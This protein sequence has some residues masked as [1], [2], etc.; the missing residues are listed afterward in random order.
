M[1]NT[2]NRYGPLAGRLLIAFIFIF[3]GYGKL[4]GFDGTVGYIA[5]KDMPLPELA[6]AAA[7]LIELGGGLMLAL[8]WKARWAAGALMVF[9]AMTAVIF[10]NFWSVAPDQVQN[11][12]IHFMKNLSIMGGLL[13]VVVHDSGPLSL[14]RDAAAGRL[15]TA[16]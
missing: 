8:G 6:A 16:R 9:T 3:A 2:L 7:I 14:R 1:E 13:Y 4:T 12:M 10:H 11:Q 5:S 15:E